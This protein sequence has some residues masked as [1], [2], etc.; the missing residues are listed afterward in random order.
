MYEFAERVG[1]TER[2]IA[3]LVL[4]GDVKIEVHELPGKVTMGDGQASAEPVT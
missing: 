3:V 1:W 4:A 2:G